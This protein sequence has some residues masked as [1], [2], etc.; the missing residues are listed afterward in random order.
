MAGKIALQVIVPG[1]TCFTRCDQ[2][3]KKAKYKESICFLLGSKSA[4]LGKLFHFY[5]HQK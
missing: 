1:H 5:L 3:P 4:Q 2:A